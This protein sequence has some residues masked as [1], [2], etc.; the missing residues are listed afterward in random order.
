MTDHIAHGDEQWREDAASGLLRRQRH[1]TAP[2]VVPRLAD[3]ITRQAARDRHGRRIHHAELVAE[4][5]ADH[6]AAQ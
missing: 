2:A 6:H 4:P 3:K 5:G 1:V